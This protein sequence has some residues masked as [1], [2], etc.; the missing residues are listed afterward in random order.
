MSAGAVRASALILLLGVLVV[1][2]VRPIGDACPDVGKLPPGSSASSRPSFS[3]PLTRTCTYTT[4]DGTQA[5][6]RYLPVVDWLVLALVAGL[7]GA[8]ITRFGAGNRPPP[9]QRP[10]RER[11]ADPWE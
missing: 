4:A 3:P 6:K 1:W 2:L 8:A 9:P 10:R 7:A 11:V 5:R